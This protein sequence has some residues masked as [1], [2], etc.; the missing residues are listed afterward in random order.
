MITGSQNVM[1]PVGATPN[2]DCE[3][4]PCCQKKTTAPNTAAS[5]TRLSSTAFTGRSTERNVRTSSRN[6]M[7]AM[8]AST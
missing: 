6:V 8:I 3:P 4:W 2:S 1:A 5:D 7:A